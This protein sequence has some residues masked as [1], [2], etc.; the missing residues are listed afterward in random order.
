MQNPAI[1]HYY[2]MNRTRPQYAAT[3]HFCGNS[4]IYPYYAGL[5]LTFRGPRWRGPP[6]ADN[7]TMAVVSTIHCP[8]QG[9]P[10]PRSSGKSMS[11]SL[12]GAQNVFSSKLI[13]TLWE[14]IVLNAFFVIYDSE[15][16][17]DYFLL[18][19]F[20]QSHCLCKQYKQCI[21]CA[22]I[23]ATEKK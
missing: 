9:C 18:R 19:R 20:D 7:W 6:T 17:I 16:G 22:T 15:L 2:N 5:S 11:V 14:D 23:E 4:V 3:R 21:H 10:P 12:K 8:V 13:C 1:V